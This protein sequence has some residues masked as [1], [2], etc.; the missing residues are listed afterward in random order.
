MDGS[1]KAITLRESKLSSLVLLNRTRRLF[2]LSDRFRCTRCLKSG[3]P[4]QDATWSSGYT[5]VLFRAYYGP[6]TDEFGQDWIGGCIQMKFFAQACQRCNEY[7]TCELDDGRAAYLVAWLHGWIA[8][9]F[10]GFR[11]YGSGYRGKKHEKKHLTKRCEAC[12]SGWCQYL[13]DGSTYNRT[14]RN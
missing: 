11:I 14:N 12:A 2:H 5:T 1:M 8:N 9:K 13:K 6:D 7:I 10:Y 3:V 4:E